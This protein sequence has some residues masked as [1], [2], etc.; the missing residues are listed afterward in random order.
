MNV[1][2]KFDGIPSLILQDIQ[3]TKR[4]GHTVD[5]SF[6]NNVK[7]IYPPTNTVVVFFGGYNKKK[8]IL[9]QSSKRSPNIFTLVQKVKIGH[10]KRFNCKDKSWLC[11]DFAGYFISK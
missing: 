1:F 11:R 8:S 5:R 7:T 2:A 9:K 6:R 10:T 4:Y 3:E